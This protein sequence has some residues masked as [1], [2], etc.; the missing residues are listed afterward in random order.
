V[1]CRRGGF[2]SSWVRVFV[3]VPITNDYYQASGLVESDNEFEFVYSEIKKF[4]KINKL[5][6]AVKHRFFFFVLHLIKSDYTPGH[7]YP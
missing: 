7:C 6:L 5:I 1:V 3:D 4:Y 2:D